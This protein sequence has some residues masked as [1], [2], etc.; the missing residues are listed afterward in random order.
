[1][2]SHSLPLLVQFEK[3]ITAS[4]SG[5]RLSSGGKRIHSGTVQNYK[6]TLRLLEEYETH[7]AQILKIG[8]LHRA[9]LATL[10]KEK[11]YW[12]RFF[13]CF[14]RF[15]YSKGYSDNYVSSMFKILK[16]FFNYLVHDKGYVIGSYNRTFRIPLQQ[17]T[18]IVLSPEQLRYLILDKEFDASLSKSLKRARDI[19]VVGCT[20]G[21]RVSDLMNLR[22]TA[23]RQTDNEISLSVITQK[24][25]TELNIPLPDYVLEILSSYKKSA[26]KYL[27]PRLAKS[28]LNLQIK[29]LAKKAGW[30]YPVP[31]IRSYKGKMQEIR[32]DKGKTWLFYEHITAHTMR[33]T[34]ITNLLIMQVPELLVRKIS[35]HAPGSKE[36]YKYVSIAQDY[37]SKEVRRAFEKL[38][39]PGGDSIF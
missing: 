24:T 26:G 18:P 33:R 37:L 35:G 10:K 29:L 32:N 38:V 14:S 30:T 34:A 25:S 3:F 19:F 9:S 12:S 4:M 6:Y 1:M 36:F 21:L 27:L 17:A 2:V 23:L 16:S 39:E 8:L 13:Q 31:K 5:K 28:N 22:K 7:T 11:K 15:L 20:I